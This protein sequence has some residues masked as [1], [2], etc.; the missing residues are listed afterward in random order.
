[1]LQTLAVSLFRAG[2]GCHIVGAGGK[3]NGQV[4]GSGVTAPERLESVA[5]TLHSFVSSCAVC[6]AAADFKLDGFLNLTSF[7]V[8]FSRL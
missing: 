3:E 4:N 2:L 1:M 7:F 8:R 6:S 5:L